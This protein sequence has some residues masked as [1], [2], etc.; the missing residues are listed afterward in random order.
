MPLP[1]TWGSQYG[2][3]YCFKTSSFSRFHECCCSA[4]KPHQN[5]HQQGPEWKM[6]ELS[7]L[8]EPL[9]MLIVLPLWPQSSSTLVSHAC[10]QAFCLVRKQLICGS[11]VVKL[12]KLCLRGPPPPSCEAC[13]PTPSTLSLWCRCT[14]REMERPCRKMEEQVSTRFKPVLFY[15]HKNNKV[16]HCFNNGEE[17]RSW[18]FVAPPNSWYL[19]SGGFL[20]SI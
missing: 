8:G 18:L 11:R 1:I 9:R 12:R 17:E 2:A 7:F 6:S 13:S 16:K 10:L 19:T 20:L 4:E 15:R 5:F 3:I 14:L